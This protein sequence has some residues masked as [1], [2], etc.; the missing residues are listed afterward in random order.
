LDSATNEGG[1]ELLEADVAARFAGPEERRRVLAALTHSAGIRT[2]P[3]LASLGP[4]ER[5]D[6]IVDGWRRYLAALAKDRPVLVWI[7]DFHW[8]ESEHVRLLDRIT[9]AGAGRLLVV[10]TARPSSRRAPGSVRRRPIL[11]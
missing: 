8:A 1:L 2:T 3:E 5:E 11:R 10:A 4:A 6:E 7:D 9:T